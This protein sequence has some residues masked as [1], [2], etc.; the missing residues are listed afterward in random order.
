[1]NPLGGRA[2]VSGSGI[3]QVGRRLGRSGL[4]LTIEACLRAIADAGLTPDDIDGVAS[5]PGAGAGGPGFSGAGSTELHDALGLRTRWHFGA[6][7]T[8]GQLGP[9]IEAALAVASGSVKPRRILVT[10]DPAFNQCTGF[11]PARRA[12]WMHA[13]R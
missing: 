2:V 10:S 5:Y 13:P 8:A 7:E 9:V 1:M 12:L 6:G 4:A 3:S 11:C